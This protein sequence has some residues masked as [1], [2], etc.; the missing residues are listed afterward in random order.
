M[1]SALA[2]SYLSTFRETWRFS[3]GPLSLRARNNASKIDVNIWEEGIQEKLRFK[4]G[5]NHLLEVTSC[6]GGLAIYKFVFRFLLY[7]FL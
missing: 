3:S 6:F 2:S 1:A 5:T 4:A 7:Y